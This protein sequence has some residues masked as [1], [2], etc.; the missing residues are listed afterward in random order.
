MKQVRWIIFL[1]VF[2]AMLQGYSGGSGTAEDPYQ[3]GSLNDLLELSATS[4]DWGAYFIQTNDIDASATATMSPNGSGGYLGFLPIGND[5]NTFTGVYDGQNHTITALQMNRTEY[6]YVREYIALFGYCF[7]ATITNLGLL[8]NNITGFNYVASLIGYAKGVT[9]ENCYSTGK[10]RGTSSYAGGIIGYADA[11]SILRKCYN[12]ADVF[13]ASFSG[14]I[15]GKSD[16]DSEIYNSYNT[17]IIEVQ[18]DTGYAGGV[19]GYCFETDMYNCYNCGALEQIEK[20]KGLYGYMYYTSI[21]N[22]FSEVDANYPYLDVYQYYKK[23]REQVLQQSTYENWDFSTIWQMEEGQIRPHLNQRELVLYTEGAYNPTSSSATLAIGRIY[24]AS[25]NPVTLTEYGYIYQKES[26]PAFDTG[27]KTATV[28]NS[29]TLHPDAIL[30]IPEVVL[31]GLDADATYY[32]RVYATDGTHIWYGNGV[33][34]VTAETDF[35]R[36]EGTEDNP[37][38]V[39]TPHH[40]DNVRLS[41]DASYPQNFY[42]EQIADIDMTDACRDGGEYWNSGSGWKYIGYSIKPFKGHY[43]GNY[44]RIIG[45]FSSRGTSDNIGLFGYTSGAEISNLQMVNVDVK[46]RYYVG[47]LVGYANSYTKIRNVSVSGFVRGDRYSGGIAGSNMLGSTIHA[48]YSKA[49]IEAGYFSGSFAGKN[50]ESNTLIDSCYSSGSICGDEQYVKGFAYTSNYAGVQHSYYDIEAARGASENL[51]TGLASSDMY[52]SASYE[53]WDFVGNWMISEGNTR[54]FFPSET[55]VINNEALSDLHATSFTLGEGTIYNNTDSPITISEYGYMYKKDSP[56][57]DDDCTK[58]ATGSGIISASSTLTITS[59]NLPNLENGAIYYAISY[60]TDGTDVWYGDAVA[61]LVEEPEFAGGDGTEEDPYQVSIPFHLNSMHNYLDACFIQTADIDLAAACAEGGD[62]WNDGAGWLPIGDYDTRFTGTYDGQGYTISGMMINRATSYIGLF[63][64]MENAEITEVVLED[65]SMVDTTADQCGALAGYVYYSSISQCSSSGTINGDNSVGGLVGYCGGNTTQ[66]VDCTN[67]ATVQAT[68]QVG[69]L[70]GSANTYASIGSCYSY[71]SVSGTTDVGG[72]IGKTNNRVSITECYNS[73]NVEG[74][75][76][77]GG[78]VGY[79]YYYSTVTNCYN[80]GC[81]IGGDRT[82]T[83]GLVGYHDY[84][85]TVTN[86]FSTGFVSGGTREVGGLVGF[87]EDNATVT[88]SYYDHRI[89]GQSDN[90]TRGYYKSTAE[91]LQQATFENWDFTDVWNINEGNSRPYLRSQDVALYNERIFNLHDTSVITGESKILN[92]SDSAITIAEYGYLYRENEPP[93]W[94]ACGKVI[95]SPESTDLSSGCCL[96]IPETP[97][98]GLQPNAICYA[99]CYAVVDGTVWYGDLSA[100]EVVEAEFAGGY[101]TADEPYEVATAYHLNNVRNYNYKYFIQTADIDLAASCAEGGQF[102]ND[103][104][105]WQPIGNSSAKSSPYYDG[106]DHIISGLYINRPSQDYVGLFG[107]LYRGKLE[108][109]TLKDVTVTG[110]NNVGSCA[111]YSYYSNTLIQHVSASGVVNGATYV[112]GLVGYNTSS[113]EITYCNSSCTVKGTSQYTGGFAGYNS[114]TIRYCYSTGDVSGVKYTGGFVGYNYSVVNNCYSAGDVTRT[115]GTEE[116][117]GGFCGYSRSSSLSYSYSLGCVYQSDGVVWGS[118]AYG[119]DDKGFVGQEYSS[120]SYSNNFYDCDASSQTTATGAIATHTAEMKQQDT[121][122]NWNFDTVWDINAATNGGYPYLRDN[123]PDV[124]LPIT[125]SSFTGCMDDG[126]PQLAWTTQSETGN[127]GWNVYR[128]ESDAFADAVLLTASL[129]AG[130]GTTSEPTDYAYTD[131]EAV[132]EGM[133]YF[134]WLESICCSG[135]SK[136]WGPVS[137]EIPSGGEEPNTPE[138]PLDLG[139]SNYP[140]PFNPST[141]ICLTLA[142]SDCA[143]AIVKIYNSRGQ[144]VRRLEAPRT[145]DDAATFSAVWDGCDAVGKAV[146]SGVYLARIQAGTHQM[147]HKM[148]MMK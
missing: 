66:F 51:A 70:I 41:I 100:I 109:L 115:S 30:D 44:H 6:G 45:L 16:N 128:A 121:F 94:D 118:E 54:P 140:N 76:N 117:F 148:V 120:Y 82:N 135:Q 53:G 63:G 108:N 38:W 74:E 73:G 79:N 98:T 87:L 18:N 134:Y 99:R 84:N 11:G 55:V 13:A 67:Y 34:I 31:T 85:S 95:I 57:T 81:V 114:A 106:Q 141:L 59:T 126:L 32:A 77:T 122:T 35:A 33:S 60:A 42:Y 113:S 80:T 97:I 48:S 143:A 43:D 92:A 61:I 83:G 142:E 15:V 23:S 91:M 104:A 21:Q 2:S 47:G 7:G 12:A 52:Q 107:Y 123:L 9:V 125:L 58:V 29:G 19:V 22:S 24:N 132:D 17:G 14:G 37:Y 69:G 56:P 1:T 137:I 5:D 138:I 103:G 27:T 136:T 130:A 25:D 133:V 101:G 28:Y 144:L 131:E 4:A 36:G 127:A 96:E 40:L 64:C 39:A 89:S 86:C 68:N 8:E 116:N 110:R 75:T 10:I 3:I 124:P 26:A 49:A 111:G 46:G 88:D 129:I 50:S 62:Y 146:S 112:G 145:A 72:L 90:G 65:C 93:T 139:V 20:A 105:G 102:Y 147:L 119:E 71:G 78:F